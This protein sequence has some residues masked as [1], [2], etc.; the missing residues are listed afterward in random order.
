[1]SLHKHQAP[2]NNDL[3]TYFPAGM[4]LPPTYCHPDMAN[5]LKGNENNENF[6]K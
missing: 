4:L 1:M 2:L 6:E 3:E 5:V